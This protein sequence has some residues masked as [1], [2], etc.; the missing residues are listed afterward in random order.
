[1]G[2][3]LEK[4]R[5]VKLQQFRSQLTTEDSHVSKLTTDNIYVSL[6]TSSS[7]ST[8]VKTSVFLSVLR[9]KIASINP[10]NRTGR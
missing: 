3:S 6:L 5:D 7:Q 10:D 1:M 8:D 4:Y 9:S 2:Q